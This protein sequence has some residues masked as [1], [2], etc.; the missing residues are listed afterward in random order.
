MP[1]LRLI[2]TTAV[3]DLGAD[4]N[5]QGVIWLQEV[6]DL[7]DEVL[8]SP[9]TSLVTTGTGKFYSNGLDVAEAEGPAELDPDYVRQLQAVY[10]RVLT[11][12]MPTAAAV[13]GHAFGGGALLAM[14]H[15][16]RVMRTERGFF[17]FPEVNIGIAFTEGMA[18]LVQSKLSAAQARDAMLTGR[19]FDGGQAA[20]AGLVDEAVPVDQ[21]VE[22]A[23]QLASAHVPAHPQTLG[24]VKEIMYADAASA[25]ERGHRPA[26][27]LAG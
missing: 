19:R 25:L 9:A 23:V 3:L 21:L 10:R 12:P 6:N 17:C 22:R 16:Y 5:R 18:A 14:A 20:A 2:G 8:A 27:A 4:Q 7:L 15:D 1:S 24:A 11:L 13:N 26:G